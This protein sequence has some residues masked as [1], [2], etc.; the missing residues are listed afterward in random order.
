MP[1][2]SI[3]A[4]GRWMTDPSLT[5][6]LQPV[7]DN[8]DRIRRQPFAHLLPLL[9]LFGAIALFLLFN[10]EQNRNLD[11]N[12]T[13]PTLWLTLLVGLL[14]GALS[15]P[16]MA[17]TLLRMQRTY[18]AWVFLIPLL[19]GIAATLFILEFVEPRHRVQSDEAGLLSNAR[20]ME[21]NGKAAS[22]DEGYFSPDAL[23]CI[24]L[25]QNFKAKAVP[26]FFSLIQNPEFPQGV[27]DGIVFASTLSLLIP[28]AMLMFVAL[29]AYSQS[30]WLATITT[31][32]FLAHPTVLFQ[33]HSA[34]VE[35]WY[36][37]F[38]AFAA[39]VFVSL[40]EQL[41]APDSSSVSR[42]VPLA[43]LALLAVLIAFAAQTRQESLASL[44][45][46]LVPLWL[47][48]ALKLRE[49]VFFFSSLAIF[50]LPV[51]WLVF[52]HRGYDLQAGANQAHGLD[53]LLQHLG[54][55]WNVMTTPVK[56]GELA[57]PFLP[58]HMW[59]AALGLLYTLIQVVRKDSVSILVLW[60]FLLALPQTLVILQTVSGDMTIEINQRYAVVFIPLIALMGAQATRILLHLRGMIR[61]VRIRRIFEP[62]ALLLICSVFAV[63]TAS[64]S[65]SFQKNIMYSNNYLTDEDEALRNWVESDDGVLPRFFIYARPWH[66]VA[67]G[68][69]SVHYNTWLRMKPER[70]QQLVER[71][72]QQVYYVRGM[73]CWNQKNWHP[74]AVEN[75]ITRD[76][77]RFELSNAL[78][79]VHSEQ[80]KSSYALEIFKLDFSSSP[81]AGRL[82]VS[83]LSSKVVDDEVNLIGNVLDCSGETALIWAWGKAQREWNCARGKLDLS[84]PST[85][86]LYYL[87]LSSAAG[88]LIWSRVVLHPGDGVKPLIELEP[89]LVKVGWGELQI[90]RSNGGNPLTIAHSH[91][92]FG[93]GAHAPSIVSYQLPRGYT[94]LQTGFGLDDEEVGGDGAV[95]KVFGD[96]RLLW[97]SDQVV[98]GQVHFVEVDIEG[99]EKIDLVTEPGEDNLYDHTDWIMPVLLES[100]SRGGPGL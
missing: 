99:V 72:G 50:V 13:Y 6:F 45:F 56:N 57:M 22:C 35:P 96:G 90:D 34:S 18:T 53:N 62:G 97:E 80:V 32:L 81:I 75:R 2:L 86:G 15:L 5:S 36:V 68:H 17:R 94:R 98:H 51:L 79:Q 85:P 47:H 58:V 63:Y 19:A 40:R 67:Y 69:S 61:Y 25:V 48:S 71:F 93:L 55:A 82:R 1:V 92:P 20:S 42:F 95:F 21:F 88:Q 11:I 14:G 10:N 12:F 100:S 84:F 9:P 77:E 30:C 54:I 7:R 26:F 41:A 39:L 44:G 37:F 33:Y 38:A 23:E 70:R 49:K 64:Y 28:T 60:F 3:N 27:S 16:L 76:C 87:H 24:S 8:L 66:F 52:A 83:G 89:V 43:P 91:Y 29:L 74:K 4:A 46:I 78:S 59:L 31:V 73:D 65:T